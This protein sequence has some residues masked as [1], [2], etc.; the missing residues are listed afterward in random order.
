MCITTCFRFILVSDDDTIEANLNTDFTCETM[1][2]NDEMI[3]I[4]DE[5]K[6]NEREKSVERTISTSSSEQLIP[7][8]KQT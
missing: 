4:N 8:E 6:S 2:K 1:Q 7:K 5:I 3:S